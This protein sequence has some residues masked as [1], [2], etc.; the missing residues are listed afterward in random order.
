MSIS[1]FF[2]VS[3]KSPKFDSGSIKRPTYYETDLDS[4]TSKNIG[5]SS[6]SARNAAALSLSSQSHASS[7]SHSLP[8]SRDVN[9]DANQKLDLNQNSVYNQ[10]E[11]WSSYRD[12]NNSNNNYDNSDTVSSAHRSKGQGQYASDLDVSRSRG[13]DGLYTAKPIFV[14][15]SPATSRSHIPTT[16]VRLLKD[17]CL[18]QADQGF[19][20]F[21]CCRRI[22][23]LR[24]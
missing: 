13:S 23:R 17:T 8:R 10:N 22:F 1:G 11:R 14:Q 5:L 12:L 21:S 16:E 2:L 20:H 4:N 6:S 7:S 18:L 19:A 9:R 3:P 15:Q 24:L